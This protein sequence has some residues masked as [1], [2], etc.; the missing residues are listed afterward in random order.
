MED[1]EAARRAD[2]VEREKKRQDEY[3]ERDAMIAE[4]QAERMEK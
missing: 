1:K 2:E 4:K 3:D